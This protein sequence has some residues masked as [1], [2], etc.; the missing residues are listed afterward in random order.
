MAARIIAFRSHMVELEVTEVTAAAAGAI[1]VAVAAMSAVAMAMSAL[2]FAVTLADL[3]GTCTGNDQ[4]VELSLQPHKESIQATLLQAEE[5]RTF[6][7]EVSRHPFGRHMSLHDR[8]Y[9]LVPARRNRGQQARDEVH[10][11]TCSQPHVRGRLCDLAHVL[12]PESGSREG[13]ESEAPIGLRGQREV[14]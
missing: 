12:A 1:L 8:Q 6:P 11:G 7:V 2:V 9:G 14:E 13:W 4:Q 3:A 10:P 5:W